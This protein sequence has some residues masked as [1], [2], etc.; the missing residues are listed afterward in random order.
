[1][2][3]VYVYKNLE[4]D[5]CIEIGGV[6]D[7]RISNVF[8]AKVSVC[9][10]NCF[11]VSFLVP[12]VYSDQEGPNDDKL[13][14]FI[15]LA[16]AHKAEDVEGSDSDSSSSSNEED[17]T[18]NRSSTSASGDRGNNS[19]SSSSGSDQETCQ[20]KSPKRPGTPILKGRGGPPPVELH[21]KTR[22]KL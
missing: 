2:L 3:Q 14:A 11:I 16:D 6:W 22:K 17:T 19:D 9:G 7:K 8:T 10:F 20:K 21:K 4:Q 15:N 12:F 5:F 1:M 18:S 13:T